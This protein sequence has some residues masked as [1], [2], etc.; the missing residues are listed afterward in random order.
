MRQRLQPTSLGIDYQGREFFKFGDSQGSKKR[1]PMSDVLITTCRD[2]RLHIASFP[3]TALF[4]AREWDLTYND[5]F[6]LLLPESRSLSSQSGLARLGSRTY[7]AIPNLIIITLVA[8]HSDV[9]QASTSCV[10]VTAN[11]SQF[12]SCIACVVCAYTVALII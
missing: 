3:T 7:V 1:S 8:P 12:S 9:M 10:W 11:R 4:A 2:Q 5:R 6:N